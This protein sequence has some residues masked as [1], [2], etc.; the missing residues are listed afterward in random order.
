V[1]KL[2]MALLLLTLS[3]GCADILPVEERN[4]DEKS[5]TLGGTGALRVAHLSD[6]HLYDTKSKNIEPAREDEGCLN[7]RLL[8]NSIEE[9]NIQNEI[10]PVDFVVV[11]GDIGVEKLI[12]G[13]GIVCS[14]AKITTNSE[15]KIEFDG[16]VRD[17]E[18]APKI[19]AGAEVLAKEIANSK[20]VDWLFVNG[21]NDLCNENVASLIYFNNYISEVK[22]ALARLNPKI[23]IV[24]LVAEDDHVATYSFPKAPNQ[25]FIGFENGSWKNNHDPLYADGH[26]KEFQYNTLTALEAEIVKQEALGKNIHLL[27]HVPN[28]DDPF[29]AESAK[30]PCEKRIS[31]NAKFE[32][33]CAV[34]KPKIPTNGVGNLYSA[35]LVRDDFRARWDALTSKSSI[36]NLLAGHFHSYER[37]V[38]L[39]PSIWQTQAYKNIEKYRVAPP[40]S[41]KNQK[42]SR[43][44]KQARGFN[45]VNI[46]Q[47]GSRTGNIYWSDQITNGQ[48]L[49][50]DFSGW[51]V[52]RS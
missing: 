40:I 18:I 7:T 29:N 38:Y 3:T 15:G 2:T 32:N 49:E 39:D 28:F 43:E 50:V 14:K 44:N 52:Q 10:S 45:L 35:W 25:V 42:V 16:I 34:I 41:I 51:S 5:G 24:N 13:T 12:E 6:P 17:E 33:N 9:I 47:D 22:K 37:D 23:K 21:N 1:K 48:C 31:T 30:E 27:F 26:N 46:N 8:K 4:L 36:K 19:K 20:I 11:T